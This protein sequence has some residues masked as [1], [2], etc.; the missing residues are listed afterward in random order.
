MTPHLN[1]LDETVLIKSQSLGFQ[2]EIW[3]LIPK[4]SFL[5]LLI[6]NIDFRSAFIFMIWSFFP[7]KVYEHF[8]YFQLP[9][10]FGIVVGIG[11]NLMI[12]HQLNKTTD[13]RSIY[14]ELTGFVCSA[15]CSVCLHSPLSHRNPSFHDILWICH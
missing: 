6:W 15:I 4:L 5:P 8:K 12:H 9:S 7:A 1:R 11:R 10:I 3:I 14:Y 13:D 2:G